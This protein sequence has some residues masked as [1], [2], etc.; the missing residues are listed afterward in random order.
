MFSKVWAFFD[1]SLLQALTL[2]GKILN[3]SCR[4]IIA[5]PFWE[6]ISRFQSKALVNVAFLGQFT[7]WHNLRLLFE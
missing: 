2:G 7:N 6:N 3:G 4:P 1:E 5:M